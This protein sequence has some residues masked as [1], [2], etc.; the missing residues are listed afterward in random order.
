MIFL[1]GRVRACENAQDKLHEQD[2]ASFPRTGRNAYCFGVDDQLLLARSFDSDDP[3]AIVYHSHPDGGVEFSA[4]DRR[5]A[6][7]DGRPLYESLAYLVIGCDENGVTG[8][9]LYAFADGD[10]RRV[11]RIDAPAG[12]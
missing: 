5:G 9:A 1:S 6:M 8:A 3:A 10:Y 7:S 11:A 4:A 2:P 12:G